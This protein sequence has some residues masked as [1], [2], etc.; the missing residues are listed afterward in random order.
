MSLIILLYFH[1][2]HF[3]LPHPVG[4]AK[5]YSIVF[6]KRKFLGE[7]FQEVPYKLSLLP[8]LKLHNAR[9]L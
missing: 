8:K 6:F 9:T 2:I 3:H 4:S 7:I 1:S 5:Q